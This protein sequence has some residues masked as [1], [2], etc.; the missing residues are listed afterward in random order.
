MIIKLST[1][2][3]S[4]PGLLARQTP[5]NT[6]KWGEH[7]FVIDQ[8]AEHYDWWVILHSSS[9][10]APQELNCDP[11]H[12]VFVSMEPP[13]WRLP[14]E[15]YAQFSHVVAC[16]GG[17][18][19]PKVIR[20][21]GLTWWAG[22]QVAFKGGHEISSTYTHDYDSFKALE[23]PAKKNRISVITSKKN[24]FP[25][26]KKRLQFLEK[27]QTHPIAEFIDFYGGWHNPIGDKLD[28]LLGYKY[29]IALENSSTDD[30]WTEKFAD[31]LLAWTLPLYNGC[32]NMS[33]YFPDGSYIPL[34]IDHFDDTVR[35]LEQVIAN[36]VYS[37]HTT[38]IRAA[39]EK[40]LD[41]YNL[42]QLL[43][44]ICDEPAKTVARCKINPASHFAERAATTVPSISIFIPSNR[45][46][47]SAWPS[48]LS[49]LETAKVTGAEVIVSDNSGD[50]QKQEKLEAIA[51]SDSVSLRYIHSPGATESVNWR[52]AIDG[53]TG[54]FVAPLADDDFLSVIEPNSFK[55]APISEDVVGIKPQIV[56]WTP[57]V[58]ITRVNNF[59]LSGNTALERVQQYSQWAQG[60]NTTLFS[61]VRRDLVISL[62][63][64]LRDWHPTYGNYIDWALVYAYVSSGRYVVN[65]NLQYVY[66]NQNWSGPT[67]LIEQR[68]VSQY[69]KVGLPAE[70]AYFALLLQGI[71][72]F[73]LIA[74]RESPVP[75]RERLEAARWVLHLHR[76]L[77]LQQYRASTSDWPPELEILV[78]RIAASGDTE[79]LLNGMMRVL[80]EFGSELAQNY[81]RFYHA[82]IGEPWGV[83]SDTNHHR[84][85]FNG[86][87]K[88]NEPRTGKTEHPLHSDNPNANP[89]RQST[90]GRACSENLDAHTKSFLSSCP[91]RIVAR[92]RNYLKK[93]RAQ[94]K[95]DLF[96]LAQ[97]NFKSEGFFVEFGATNGI[98]LSNTYLLETE[99]G[100][101]GILAEPARCWHEALKSNRKSHIETRCVW[102]DSTS[103]L[104]FNEVNA[105]ELSTIQGYGED[106]A[107]SQTRKNGVQYEVESISLND[108]LTKY[109]APRNIDYLSLDTEGSEYEILED[110]DFSQHSFQ[111][112]TCEHNHTPA[113]ERIFQLLTQKGYR[114]VFENVSL[115]DDWY[116]RKVDEA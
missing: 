6:L 56:L 111:V 67:D 88:Q 44:E 54:T 5:G 87:A 55:L 13:E 46:L 74:R 86:H 34:D 73:I 26:H 69:T 52:A 22:L 45:P 98:D 50:A 21:N 95:Q 23:C 16:D 80:G 100:W 64:I 60:N 51:H 29:H 58:G 75:V 3:G 36:D 106:D 30:Y 92:C 71:D 17:V 33:R 38:A 104:K 101:T 48:I 109:G 11:S 112:I 93:S 81:A 84:N 27:L 53:T 49:G 42:F 15:F 35:L 9:V 70:A 63:E 8:E 79:S 14:A 43:V 25:G 91:K 113:R 103:L 65:P 40:V 41:D 96:V 82:V 10:A 1:G 47:G 4:Q 108:L 57:D 83:V 77:F 102:R 107:H 110:F 66:V 85:V 37:Q 18:Q 19:H 115:W 68:I 32:P 116:I 89:V 78:R 72:A 20:R 97:T 59:P 28:A 39:R 105:P 76:E 24:F 99:F 114:R 31:P 94:L 61:F 62:H 90:P 7:T 2:D 12:V